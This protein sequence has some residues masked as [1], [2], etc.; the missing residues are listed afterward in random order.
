MQIRLE[1]AADVSAIRAVNLAA[2]ETA[3]EADL[4]AA[5]RAEAAPLISMVA[6]D[7]P[8]IVGHILFSPVTLDSDPALQ[9]AGLAPMA[10]IPAR[11]RQGIGSLLV[12]QGLE[13][14]RRAGF[15]ACV[16]LGHAEYYPRFGFAPASRFDLRS[17]YDVPDDVFMA[18][19]L[20][21]GALARTSGTV[22]YHKVFAGL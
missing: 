10:V 3:L 22:R 19:E 17:E 2:F 4:V 9:I 15:S 7:G 5:L 14:C 1:S 6:E 11:Q 8:A 21:P 13:Q 12:R 18:M 20:M 16:V